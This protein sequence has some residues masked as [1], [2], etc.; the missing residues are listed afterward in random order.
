[1]YFVNSGYFKS[2]PLRFDDNSVY[3]ISLSV[4]IKYKELV[5][6]QELKE[7][8]FTVERE[9]DISNIYY[10]FIYTLTETPKYDPYDKNKL[11]SSILFTFIGVFLIYLKISYCFISALLFFGLILR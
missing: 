4:F 10:Y 3:F 2:K 11:P 7:E 5:E 6:K 1:M 8:T 9:K